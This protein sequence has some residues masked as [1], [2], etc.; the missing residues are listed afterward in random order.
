MSDK[1]TL[2]MRQKTRCVLFVEKQPAFLTLRLNE[3]QLQ[4]LRNEMQDQ[5]LEQFLCFG[6][7]T[8]YFLVTRHIVFL[9]LSMHFQYQSTGFF[10]K[11]FLNCKDRLLNLYLPMWKFFNLHV[12]TFNICIFYLPR[13][14]PGVIITE[15]VTIYSTT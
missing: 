13:A 5:L 4:L 9:V 1:S 2:E 10:L 8:K 3:E 15:Y 7:I 6:H 14:I 11:V 12:F